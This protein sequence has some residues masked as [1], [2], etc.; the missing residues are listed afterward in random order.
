MILNVKR[1]LQLRVIF[2]P[3]WT[4]TMQVKLTFFSEMLNVSA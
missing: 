3:N 4:R 1:D 2:T